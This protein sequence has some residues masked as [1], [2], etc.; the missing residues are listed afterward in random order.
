M[1]NICSYFCCSAY[2]P[3]FQ[4][5]SELLLRVFHKR[6]VCWVGFWFIF[7]WRTLSGWQCCRKILGLSRLFPKTSFTPFGKVFVV[8]HLL[9]SQAVSGQ[10]GKSHKVSFAY[11]L[12]PPVCLL[13]IPVV[14]PALSMSLSKISQ[15]NAA[16]FFF[17]SVRHQLFQCGLPC[18]CLP[19]PFLFAASFSM[20]SP[21]SYLVPYTFFSLLV[22]GTAQHFC[23][24]KECQEC[25]M[26]GQQ[27]WS[28]VLC[29]GVLNFISDCR[30]VLPL[31]SVLLQHC[32]FIPWAKIISPEN[33]ILFPAVCFISDFSSLDI[34]VIK[35][36]RP[37]SLL[38]GTDF[39]NT[40]SR[41]IDMVGK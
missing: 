1:M 36:P 41:L 5:F 27:H 8:C 9:Y 21:P 18:L 17:F 19:L 34:C 12:E 26:E 28:E 37:F 3:P 25:A 23:K 10:D 13:L 4:T 29:V 30:S 31:R 2:F 32:T 15:E 39:Y 20:P 40:L 24:C 35:Q 6:H 22:S 33:F 16:F 38:N 7:C 14:P 11:L